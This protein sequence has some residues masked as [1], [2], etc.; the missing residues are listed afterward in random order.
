MTAAITMRLRAKLIGSTDRSLHLKRR[1]RRG[2]RA[3]KTKTGCF[4]RHNRSGTRKEIGRYRRNNQC[5]NNDAEQN[6]TINRT[7]KLSGAVFYKR[8]PPDERKNFRNFPW[9]RIFG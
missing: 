2:N 9:R 7:D 1:V 5:Q 4:T 6:L 3:A 8:R